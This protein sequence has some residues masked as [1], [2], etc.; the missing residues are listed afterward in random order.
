MLVDE[1][2]APSHPVTR[3][4]EMADRFAKIVNARV[5]QESRR[6][7]PSWWPS[8]VQIVL[9]ANDSCMG[10]GRIFQDALA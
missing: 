8:G 6:P 2:P 4:H 10:R 1:H 9:S 3:G 7:G 5:V